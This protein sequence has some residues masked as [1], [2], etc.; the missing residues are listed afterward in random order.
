M[1]HPLLIGLLALLLLLATPLALADNFDYTGNSF[2]L[3]TEPDGDPDLVSSYAYHDG[4]HYALCAYNDN[5]NCYGMYKYDNTSAPA[6]ECYIPSTF[7][8]YDMAM[9]TSTGEILVSSP[10]AKRLYVYH[11]GSDFCNGT[12]FGTKTSFTV[13]SSCSLSTGHNI[14]DVMY[15][16]DN[17]YFYVLATS[18]AVDNKICIYDENTYNFVGSHNLSSD[19]EP[20]SSEYYLYQYFVEGTSTANDQLGVIDTSTGVVLYYNL[21]DRLTE[22]SLSD[23]YFSSN[24]TGSR[25]VW[26]NDSETVYLWGG[27]HTIYEH[28]YTGIG[29]A[30]NF[31]YREVDGVYYSDTQCFDSDD[32]CLGGENSYYL[33]E[34]GTI[35]NQRDDCTPYYVETACGSDGGIESCR[36]GCLTKEGYDE[37][38]DLTYI[39]GECAEVGCTNEC[40][41]V[42]PVCTSS[43]SYAYCDDDYDS[44][45][46]LELSSTIYCDDGEICSNGECIEIDFNRSGSTLTL[47]GI[48]LRPYTTDDTQDVPLQNLA[49]GTRYA[50]DDMT[51]E[52]LNVQTTKDNHLQRFSF[53]VAGEDDYYYTAITCDYEQ[54]LRY[55]ETFQTGATSTATGEYSAAANIT[56][57]G[58]S[59]YWLTLDTDATYNATIATTNENTLYNASLYTEED[60]NATLAFH[61]NAGEL[62]A[63][64][65]VRT[66]G[67]TVQ[68]IERNV[69]DN[70]A[71][72]LVNN[73]GTG[74]ILD[75]DLAVA[76]D[77]VS[78]TYAISVDID[79]ETDD[80][81][82]YSV[83]VSLNADRDSSTQVRWEV[84][85]GELYLDNVNL[86]QTGG[87]PTYE[88]SLT[89][90]YTHI[91][92][93]KEAC[94]TARGY[95]NIENSPNYLN[96]DDQEICITI[97]NYLSS[98][99]ELTTFS[100][101]DKLIIVLGGVALILSIFLIIGASTN[102]MRPA[103][104]AGT[105][106]G[107]LAIIVAGI[108]G[109]I[110]AWVIIVMVLLTSFIGAKVLGVGV[111]G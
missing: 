36:G 76:I 53:D 16:K 15:N 79:R 38:Y 71:D 12:Y 68:V 69:T 17:G 39:Y 106:F 10:S 82:V 30:S 23:S 102:S 98:K 96:Y 66:I 31:P 72:V 67:S 60:T 86:A 61:N 101:T 94:Y 81:T 21:N 54:Q 77:Y 8:S 91:C 3:G 25:G 51:P 1:R 49:N 108:I 95:L 45:V 57:R 34:A 41:I 109:W 75:I 4:N 7:D 107:T 89:G 55:R 18:G 20:G 56:D 58:I 88:E 90:S 29:N 37:T 28:D 85:G 26:I 100:K 19:I 74:A 5:I 65:H 64:V 62:I 80:Y 70:V 97:G 11:S 52:L 63:S 46:C 111:G 27:S 43:K 40:N 93:Y 24:L 47:P 32:G 87:F 99:N 104:I 33:C 35:F 22:N 2:T 42:G 44:D 84:Q 83:P 78:D 50:Y 14:R 110:P 9:S 105:A 13:T 48:D 73:T 59:D 103:L 6:Q 92:K